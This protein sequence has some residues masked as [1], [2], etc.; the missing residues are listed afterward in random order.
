[1]VGIILDMGPDPSGPLFPHWTA[2]V[3]TVAPQGR[4][5][6]ILDAGTGWPTKCPS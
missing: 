6:D 3:F 5:E 4:D 1:M 2:F